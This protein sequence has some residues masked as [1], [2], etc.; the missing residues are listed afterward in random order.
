[1]AG[2]GTERQDPLIYF[3]TNISPA[4]IARHQ[5]N[6]EIEQ[7]QNANAQ[8]IVIGVAVFIGVLLAYAAVLHWRKITRAADAAVISGLATGVRAARVARSKR[9][10]LIDRVLAKADEP[11][12]TPD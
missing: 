10:A 1:M 12:R 8:M 5:H 7:Q 9:D 6:W 2:P 4:E 11:T 3:R